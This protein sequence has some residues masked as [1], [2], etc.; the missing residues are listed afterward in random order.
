MCLTSNVGNGFK[1]PSYAE[2]PVRLLQRE[3]VLKSCHGTRSKADYNE[4]VA[5]SLSCDNLLLSGDLQ[6]QPSPTAE[7]L[8]LVKV[9][10]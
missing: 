8:H 6:H 9:I 1:V 7:L 5:Y 10:C 3:G 2:H 4:Q